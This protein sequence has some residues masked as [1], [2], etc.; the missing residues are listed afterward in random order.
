M[1]HAA[2]IPMKSLAGAKMRLADVL[3]ARQRSELSL[4]ML[5]DV[6]SACME[7]GC[8][9]RVAVISD[10]SD[11]FWHARELGATP[12][13]AP[14]M[15]SGLNA[16]LTFGQRYLARRVAVAELLVLPADLPLL[17]AEEVRRVVAA[18]PEAGGVV[19]V[20]STDGGTNALALRPPEA[21]GMHFGER[22]ADAHLAACLAAGVTAVELADERIAFDVDS[23]EDVAG[24][25]AMQVSAATRGWVEAYAHSGR[26]A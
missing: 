16:D 13:A 12:I 7:S 9:E 2:L 15:V 25:A 22:S 10:D 24:L 18:V 4:A 19:V 3:D 26:S 6:I 17:R 5:T 1:T 21:I 14:A 11:V 8:F 20:R 23:A